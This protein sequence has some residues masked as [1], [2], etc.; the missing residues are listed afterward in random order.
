MECVRRTISGL[1]FPPTESGTASVVY[2]ITFLEKREIA[3]AT[4]S[5]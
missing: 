1:S 4:H 2:P 3:G 5:R